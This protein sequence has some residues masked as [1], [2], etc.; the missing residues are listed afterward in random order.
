MIL[1]GS[2]T[3]QFFNFVDEREGEDATK[4][5]GEGDIDGDPPNLGESQNVAS[6]DMWDDSTG[7]YITADEDDVE[8]NPLHSATIGSAD[9]LNDPHDNKD[10]CEVVP[11]DVVY[12]Y[13]LETQHPS[14]YDSTLPACE[15]EEHAEEL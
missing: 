15:W 14:E 8:S 6:C 3:F 12:N 1:S 4:W 9:S 2:T 7:E 10:W 11:P 5:Q 13:E